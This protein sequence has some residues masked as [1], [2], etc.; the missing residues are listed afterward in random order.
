MLLT[1]TPGAQLSRADALRL[2][3]LATQAVDRVR[4]ELR[5]EAAAPAVRRLKT[6]VEQARKGAVTSRDLR[7]LRLSRRLFPPYRH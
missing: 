2:D 5:P 1:T 4:A 3:A 6:L 7:I